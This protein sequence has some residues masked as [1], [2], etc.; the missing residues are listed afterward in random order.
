MVTS[1]IQQIC[2]CERFIDWVRKEGMKWRR[3]LSFRCRWNIVR[4]C[5]NVPE[6]ARQAITAAHK[7]GHE[8][9][10][11]YGSFSRNHRRCTGTAFK[12]ND[13]CWRRLLRGARWGDFAQSFEKEALLRLIDFLKANQIEYYL[14]SNQGFFASTNLRNRLIEIVLAG[15]PV[16]SEAGK[17]RVQTILWFLDLLIED[18]AKIDYDDVNKVSFINHSIPYEQSMTN[19]TNNSKWFAVR[20]LFLVSDS[21]EI[22]IKNIHKK[23]AIDFLLNHLGSITKIPWRLVTAIMS[24]NVW[25]CCG[26][27]DGQ[28][29]WT[30]IGSSWQGDGS[31]RRRR[32]AQAPKSTVWCNHW[33]KR[34]HNPSAF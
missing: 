34:L 26:N 11:V 25:S 15:E 16:E 33:S 12:W 22:G 3:K 17:Q 1:W 31:T 9:F 2:S 4:W 32:I 6:S 30:A 13:W 8:F 20:Y 14:E 21:G 7:K 24:R 5:G 19:T 29:L 28:C 18:E 10:F 27:C 23:T